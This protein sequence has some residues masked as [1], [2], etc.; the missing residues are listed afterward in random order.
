MKPVEIESLVSSL[1]V[2]LY[3]FVASPYMDNRSEAGG[4]VEHSECQR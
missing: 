4:V 1:F 3:I 2:I